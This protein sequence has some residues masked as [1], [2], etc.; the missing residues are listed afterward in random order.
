M[1]RRAANGAVFIL[2]VVRFL[3]RLSA[4]TDCLGERLIRVLH[5]QRNIPHAIAMLSDVIRGRIVRRHGRSQ[6][7]VRLALTQRI[8]SSLP[9]ARFQ[10]T[11]SNLRKA[12]P[13]AIKV[14]CLPGVAY[15]EFDVVNALKLKWILHPRSPGFHLRIFCPW[16]A[17]SLRSELAVFR[18]RY[19]GSHSRYT[20]ARH[21]GFR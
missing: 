8:R 5:F 14:S 10:S 15:P 1:D 17:S 3:G 7:K 4:S 19:G 11:V 9:L 20:S 21:P 12:E 6:N 13:L 18:S 2:H 16:S